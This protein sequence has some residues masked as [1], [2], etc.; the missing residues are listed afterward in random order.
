M[1][2]AVTGCNGSVGRRV[3]TLALRAG[4]TV[5]GIDS[6]RP[7]E[8]PAFFAHADFV[9]S[10]VDLRE[11][12]GAVEAIRGCEAVIHLAALPTPR[13]YLVDTHNT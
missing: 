13:D 7:P 2:L 4:H 6:A 12:S 8:D 3:C 5:H 10:E 11:Y 9:F 1:K